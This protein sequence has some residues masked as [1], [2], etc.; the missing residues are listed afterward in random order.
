MSESSNDSQRVKG[1]LKRYYLTPMLKKNFQLRSFPF[2]LL[3]L[4]TLFHN[5]WSL[6]STLILIWFNVS[7]WSMRCSLWKRKNL[8]LSHSL[9][10]L[11]IRKKWLRMNMTDCNVRLVKLTSLKITVFKFTFL[12]TGGL[13]RF[14]FQRNRARQETILPC[15]QDVLWWDCLGLYIHGMIVNGIFQ[16]SN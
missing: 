2:Y 6:K 7:L 13:V 3:I 1:F 8:L 10:T 9:V 11:I 16:N 15:G 12:T 5:N 14:P 4:Q